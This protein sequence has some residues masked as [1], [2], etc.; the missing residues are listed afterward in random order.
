MQKG[1]RKPSRREQRQPVKYRVDAR[2][3][4]NRTH[5]KGMTCF[6]DSIIKIS[7]SKERYPIHCAAQGPIRVRVKC[8]TK[9]LQ[10]PIMLTGIAERQRQGHPRPRFIRFKR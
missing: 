9:L 7:G 3:R 6:E 4:I 8:C 1:F 2:A 10:S 5:A